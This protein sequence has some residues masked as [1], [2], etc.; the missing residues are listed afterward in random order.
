MCEWVRVS[1]TM[2]KDGEI[3]VVRGKDHSKECVL[4]WESAVGWKE[5]PGYLRHGVR[6]IVEWRPWCNCSIEQIRKQTWQPI[7]KDTEF[8]EY[9]VTDGFMKS[10]IA[11]GPYM[12]GWAVMRGPKIEGMTLCVLVKPSPPLPEL[13]VESLT[14]QVKALRKEIARLQS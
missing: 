12:T 5:A 13:T 9:W 6:G 3:C 7:T 14:E 11:R 8:G 10:R 2:P 4:R 1:G